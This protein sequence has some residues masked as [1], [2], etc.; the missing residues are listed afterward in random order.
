[1]RLSCSWK[2]NTYNEN[3]LRQKTSYYRNN[4]VAAKELG[5]CRFSCFN[6]NTKAKKMLRI[7]NA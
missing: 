4:G 5:Y 2:K 3:N 7:E 1:M 6:L